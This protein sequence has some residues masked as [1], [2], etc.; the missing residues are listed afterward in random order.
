MKFRGKLS[1]IS[2]IRQFAN[3]ITTITK[4]AKVC[5]LRINESHLYFILTEGSGG[6]TVWAELAPTHFFTEF[7]MEGVSADK[8]EIYLEFQG[9]QLSKTLSSLKASQPQSVKMKLTKKHSPCLTFEIELMTSTGLSR[10][11]VHDI[12]V[13]VVPRRLWSEYDEPAM[14]DFHVSIYLPQFKMLRTV[15]ERMKNLTTNITISANREGSLSL[16]VETDVVSVETHFK[17]LGNP[18]VD[19]SAE[20]SSQ[21]EFVSAMINIKKLNH[22]LWGDQV[23]PNKVVCNV[24]KDKMIHLFLLHD[25]VSIQYF[26]PAVAA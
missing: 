3:V 1:E 9:D 10:S 2:C 14:P 26:I 7:N 25:D 19:Q 4:L 6:P 16:S 13:S 8:N 17:D 24:V 22:F 15:V 12:P 18:V 11:V 20:V 23:N 5:V 21:S